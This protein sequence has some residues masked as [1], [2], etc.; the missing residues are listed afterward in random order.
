MLLGN[1]RAKQ[2]SVAV[3]LD[4]IFVNT[5]RCCMNAR[6]LS[7][8]QSLS[9]LLHHTFPLS[10]KLCEPRVS[11]REVSVRCPHWAVVE[12]GF[13]LLKLVTLS[14]AVKKAVCRGSKDCS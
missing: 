1:T 7:P 12:E 8:S 6:V 4:S 14:L 13:V 10:N 9:L 5:G 3:C 2:A 11:W